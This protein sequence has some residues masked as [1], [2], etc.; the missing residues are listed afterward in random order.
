MGSPRSTQAIAAELIER[1]LVPSMS[2]AVISKGQIEAVQAIGVADASTGEKVS[3]DTLFEA[4]SLTKPLVA[5]LAR[6]LHRQGL[7]TGL[8]RDLGTLP[9]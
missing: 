2:L 6:R 8:R 3:V 1:R 5:E 9:D 4:A 7:A